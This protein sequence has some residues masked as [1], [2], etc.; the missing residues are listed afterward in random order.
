[1]FLSE[2]RVKSFILDRNNYT[3]LMGENIIYP[4]VSGTEVPINEVQIQGAKKPENKRRGN[5]SSVDGL[6]V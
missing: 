3:Q 6:N 5:Q 4:S 2:L 1:M